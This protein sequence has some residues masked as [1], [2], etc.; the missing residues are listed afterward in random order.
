MADVK[1]TVV[2]RFV[3]SS[4]QL[5]KY[6]FLYFKTDVLSGQTRFIKIDE[7]DEG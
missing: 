5:H 1:E 3:K 4:K 2:Y 6:Y 7:V